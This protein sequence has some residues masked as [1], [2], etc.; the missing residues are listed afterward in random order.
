LRERR[1][2]ILAL[3]RHFAERAC[4]ESA[5]PVSFSRAAVGLL[6]AY[7]W[8]GNIRELEN[9]VVRAV[10]LCDQTVRPEDLPERVRTRTARDG[11]GAAVVAVGASGGAASNGSGARARTAGDEGLISLAELESRH[12]ARVLERMNGNKQAAARVL[13]INR[14]TLQR[15]LKRYDL[16]PP[17]ADGGGD[18]PAGNSGGGHE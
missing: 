10:A 2:D 4:G 7:A 12:I 1:E 8:P 15:I 17:G 13:G 16:E 11:D 14:T 5:Q 6:E 3:A 9:A 18:A